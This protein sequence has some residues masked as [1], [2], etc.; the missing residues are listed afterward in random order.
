M[1]FVENELSYDRFNKKADQI[2]R[3]IFRGSA[4]GGEMNE[5]NVMPPTAQALKA[6]Y[7]EVLEGTRLRHGGTPLFT[8]HDK[9]FN[10]DQF[11]FAD[12]NFLEVF[13]LPLI[14][15]NSKTALL[16]PNTAVISE[17]M[18]AKYFGGE[19]PIGKVLF[20]KSYNSSYKITGVMEKIPVNSHFHFDLFVSMAGN[21]EAKDPSWMT[22]NFYTYLVLPK[23]YDYKQLEAKLPQV[24]EKYMGPQV[25]KAMGLTF[26]EFKQKGN[27]LG[28]NLQ[29]LTDI[30]LHSNLSGELEAGGDIKYVYI[31]SAISIFMLIIACINFMNLS[32]A[33]ASKRAKEI[34]IR[35]VLGSEKIELVKQFLTESVL[36][37]VL[38]L[39]VSVLLVLAAL[40]LFNQLS[41]INLSLDISKHVWFIPGLLFFGLFVGLLAG[42]YPA[43]VLS[44]FKPV[45][46]LKGKFTTGNKTTGL[47]SGLV[48][49]QF[50]ISITLIVCTTVVYKQL[51][52]IQNKELGYQKDHVLVL[53]STYFLGA[54]EKAFY[55]QLIQDSRITSASIS[56]YVPAGASYSN[57]FLVY[58]DNNTSQLVK[59][60]RYEVDYNYVQTLGMKITRGR[61]F[62][63]DYGTDSAGVILN[64]TAVRI[65][66]WDKNPMGHTITR[67]DNNGNK[68]T[69]NVIGVVK[70]FHFKSLR[71]R[72][73]PLVMTLGN[74]SGTIILKMKTTDVSSLISFIKS[75]WDSYNTGASFVY[76]FLDDSFNKDYKSELK[77]G[78]ILAVFSG[79][80]V[81]V[82]SLGL[83]GLAMFTAR[84]RT[85]EIGIRKVLGASVF[86]IT[87]LL[88]KD[89]IKLV[90]VALLIASPL[91]WY[92]MNTW[93]QD[94]EY[95]TNMQWWMFALAGVLAI[96]IAFIT[97]SFQAIKAAL[98]NPIKSLRTE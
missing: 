65:F 31:F 79:L 40:P 94:F 61:N 38:A 2:V 57:N 52:Y 8:Y 88:S 87:S 20:N 72:I 91:A 22:S 67:T 98:A 46:V 53:P 96:L 81:L 17:A 90:L 25:Q 68:I 9:T 84:Q 7:P 34:G 86:S 78:K 14:K 28:L 29:P 92:V 60:L 16:H 33:G 42:S 95:R 6:D 76:S 21:P 62:S 73:S 74:N 54:N 24:V 70:D 85:K 83:F 19:D 89:F 43:F 23:G 26:A 93:L 4:A 66:G 37:A 58:P 35:K 41:G 30:H 13:T 55:N 1:L 71:E 36:L 50:F 69:L 82:A 12:S 15:G 80:T 27:R 48:V 97:I 44:S 5:A 18:A 3:V 47:R 10:T 49:F 63:K 39:A 45:L 75:K 32:T 56:G 51:I 64:E 59:T 77:I 11:A